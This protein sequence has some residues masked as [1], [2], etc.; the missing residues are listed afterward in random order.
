MNLKRKCAAEA[1]GT[2]L[3]AFVGYG[4]VLFSSPSGD[5]GNLAVALAFGGSVTGLGYALGHISGCHLNPAI[6]LG[7]HAAGR[8]PRVTLILYI[9]AQSLGALIASGALFLITHDHGAGPSQS[10]DIANGYG[11]NSPQGFGL[12]A[13][14]LTDFVL[15]YLFVLVVLGATDGRA[16]QRFAPLATGAIFGAI[17]LV[18][19]PV[20]NL[21]ANPALSTGSAVVTSSTAVLQLWVFWLSPMLGGLVAGKS[22]RQ[23]GR[24]L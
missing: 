8:L 11:A 4:T 10:A 9:L 6:S 18:G 24:P 14:L 13:S 16:S 7:M 23:I 1:I 20:I 22:Y 21:P 3:L 2:G 19:M 15:G 12:A 5:Q 17:C